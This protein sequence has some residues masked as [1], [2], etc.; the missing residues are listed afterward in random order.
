[1]VNSPDGKAYLVG[2]GAS[3][4]D[5][6]QA[7]ML[8]DQVYMARVEPTVAAISDAS[9][10]EFYAGGHGA[11]A[12]WAKGIANAKPLVDWTNH[13]GVV[14]MT[15]MAGIKKY[16]LSISTASV[17]PMMTH[18][19]D[20]Y[21]LESDSITGPWSMVTYMRY[22]GPEAYFLNQPSKF[23][24][25]QADTQAKT[26]DAFLMY[27]ANFAFHSGS[28]PPNSAYHMNLQQARFP[29]SDAFAARLESRYK[30]EAQ[31]KK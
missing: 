18:Q 22:F 31:A 26:Y 17:Y 2:H 16:V 10:W 27:S 15:Y 25:K 30:A 21:F 13:T 14:T 5:S 28:N 3:S 11:T 1:M 7:W 8:G 29:L 9:A 19:F 24:A 6:I 23:L 4:P 20:S 12:K